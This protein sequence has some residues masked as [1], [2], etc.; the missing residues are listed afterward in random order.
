[1]VH[2]IPSGLV[3]ARFDGKDAEGPE[4]D[5]SLAQPETAHQMPSSGAHTADDQM[6]E[7]MVT[8][9]NAG[10]GLGLGMA[11]TFVEAVVT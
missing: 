2:V 7:L 11:K 8:V 4:V 10:T 1:M 3:A 6:F 5:P 9:A